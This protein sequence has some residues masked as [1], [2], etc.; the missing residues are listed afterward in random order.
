[1]RF[2]ALLAADSDAQ[3]LLREERALDRLLD[4]APR[5]KLSE[6]ALA[7]RIVAAAVGEARARRHRSLFSRVR[8][9]DASAFVRA[10]ARD[11]GW[12]AAALMA[13]SLLLGVF[14]G[15]TGALDPAFEP[16]T[17]AAAGVSE[18][19]ADAGLIALGG[20]EDGIFEEDL[21]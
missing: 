19:E 15:T 5:P 8:E 20:D 11:A 12:P 3:R 18:I 4:L 21:L 16:L 7:R 17:S 2:A 9:A 1:L 6:D 13:A 10:T 14:A